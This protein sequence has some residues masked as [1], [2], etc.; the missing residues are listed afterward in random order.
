MS[1]CA[2]QVA[3]RVIQRSS[4]HTLNAEVACHFPHPPDSSNERVREVWRTSGEARNSLQRS[5]RFRNKAVM[6]GRASAHS[7][8]RDAVFNALNPQ[9]A[10]SAEDRLRRKRVFCTRLGTNAER[11]R[12]LRNWLKE[13]K[14]KNAQKHMEDFWTLFKHDRIFGKPYM[15]ERG[16]GCRTPKLAE[17][18]G[19]KTRQAVWSAGASAHCRFYYR[20][21]EN[22]V[23]RTMN[24]L[25]SQCYCCGLIFSRPT[26]CSMAACPEPEVAHNPPANSS[27]PTRKP[28]EKQ[29]R[30]PSQI[31]HHPWPRRRATPA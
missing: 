13:R 20:P 14:A 3:G 1:R 2:R 15:Q 24:R 6:T 8:Q 21:H 29:Q 12:L 11:A 5:G 16:L 10:F 28:E 17:W 9:S 31:S 27:P 7:L 23:S 30:P 26:L 18:S 19:R 4:L 22:Q 25:I